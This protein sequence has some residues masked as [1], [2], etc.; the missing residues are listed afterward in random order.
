MRQ[1]KD[2]ARA[3][4]QRAEYAEHDHREP[5]GPDWLGRPVMCAE[6]RRRIG[7]QNLPRHQLRQFVVKPLNPLFIHACHRFLG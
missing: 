6:P 5:R 7:R 1:H 3:D 2:D 4:Q